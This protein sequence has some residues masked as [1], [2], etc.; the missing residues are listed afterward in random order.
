MIQLVTNNQVHT[1]GSLFSSLVEDNF[2][3]LSHVRGGEISAYLLRRKIIRKPK[4]TNNNAIIYSGMG[5]SKTR[6]FI[7]RMHTIM[8]IVS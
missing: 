8:K 5:L 6:V 2:S 3:T 7:N 1:I 4:M